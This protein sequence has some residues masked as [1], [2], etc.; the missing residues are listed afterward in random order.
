M[1]AQL[2]GTIVSLTPT[3]LVLD[4]AGVGYRI[5]IPLST[6]ERYEH[7]SGEITVLTHYHVRED[8]HQLYGF[9]TETERTLFRNLISIT[10]IGPRIAQSILS[11]LNVTEL[12][13]AIATGNIAALTGIAGVGK[14]TAERIVLELRNKIAPAEAVPAAAVPTSADLKI[15]S[16]TIVALMSLGHTRADAERALRNALQELHGEVPSVEQLVRHALR[17]TSS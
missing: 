3:E 8:A 7:A 12:Q 17:R 15:R 13:Q 10:G 5:H 1:I 11:G 9:G 16:E 6:Y 4:V 2:R 14:K